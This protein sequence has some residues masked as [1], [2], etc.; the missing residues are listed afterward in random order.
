MAFIA[1][2]RRHFKVGADAIVLP[3]AV[4]SISVIAVQAAA[5]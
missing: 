2:L 4:Q 5:Q 3:F 1:L